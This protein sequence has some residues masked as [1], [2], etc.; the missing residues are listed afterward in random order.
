[1][2]LLRMKDADFQVSD[3]SREVDKE[4]SDQLKGFVALLRV[5]GVNDILVDI[6]V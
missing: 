1:M 2:P 4:R 3:I 5:M 6:L